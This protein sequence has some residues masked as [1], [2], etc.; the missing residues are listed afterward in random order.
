MGLDPGSIR[1][2]F[3]I[4]EYSKSRF[5]HI[6]SGSIVMTEGE[7]MPQRLHSL[8]KDLKTLMERYQPDEFAIES[9]F[10][11]RNA[12][13]ALKLGQARGVALLAAA[14]FGI[15]VS[16]YSPTEIKASVCGSGRA[17]K[18]Q[19]QHMVRYLMKLKPAFE[20]SSPDH[21]DALAICLAHGQTQLSRVW[22]EN[23]R[24]PKRKN[25][26]QKPQPIHH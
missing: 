17:D 25:N 14:E 4:I 13:S 18:A 16:E 20:Y 22:R 12:Q 19:V 10:F 21:A 11:S 5:I 15:H 9:V 6:N 8:Y 26:S 2:G 3:G 23:D 1:A 7:S 24:S